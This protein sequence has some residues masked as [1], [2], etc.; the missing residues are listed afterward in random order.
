MSFALVGAG[1]EREHRQPPP[2]SV[3]V[4]WDL[5]R[6]PG[7]TAQ[8]VRLI[9]P[10][11]CQGV[12]ILRLLLPRFCKQVQKHICGAH[13]TLARVSLCDLIQPTRQTLSTSVRNRGCFQPF[14]RHTV[15]VKQLDGK[16]STSSSQGYRHQE[17]RLRC[18]GEI[19]DLWRLFLALLQTFCVTLAL[20]KQ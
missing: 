10:Q 15:C 2:W 8:L 12:P 11:R 6:G 17:R 7:R 13:T 3:E 4:K 16:G 20:L 18:W 19:V 5:Q 1:L 14:A 9:Y